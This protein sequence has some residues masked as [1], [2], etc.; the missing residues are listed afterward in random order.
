VRRKGRQDFLADIAD[1]ERFHLATTAL[2][3][4]VNVF[5]LE[6]D[7][8]APSQSAYL[9][10]EGARVASILEVLNKDNLETSGVTTSDS[11]LRI[12]CFFGWALFRKRLD[13]APYENLVAFYERAQ[14]IPHFAETAPPV[15]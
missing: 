12:A 5:Q 3:S 9:R 11:V 7:G 1:A 15:G 8:I 13:L 14:S 2:A 10:R 6:K 4:T